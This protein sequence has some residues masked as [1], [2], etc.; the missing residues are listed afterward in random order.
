VGVSEADSEIGN[1]DG[2]GA[3]ADVGI[4]RFPL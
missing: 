1:E 4:K 2:V 3:V